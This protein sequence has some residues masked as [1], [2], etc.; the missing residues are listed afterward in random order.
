MFGLP[1]QETK[2][3]SLRYVT[4]RYLLTYLLTVRLTHTPALTSLQSD[5][6]SCTTKIIQEDSVSLRHKQNIRHF[7][8][9]CKYAV[10]GSGSQLSRGNNFTYVS[11]QSPEPSLTASSALGHG[12]EL[13]NRLLRHVLILETWE[14][15]YF[16]LLG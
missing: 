6:S 4:L 5:F 8:G 13:H 12:N 2:L 15:S 9:N 10:L 11:P 1:R 16:V 14:A 3:A 7:T